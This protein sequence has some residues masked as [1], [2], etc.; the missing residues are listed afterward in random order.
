[1]PRYTIGLFLLASLSAT[2]M[3][4]SQKMLV[5]YSSYWIYVVANGVAFVLSLVAYLL[6]DGKSSSIQRSPW[7]LVLGVALVLLNLGYVRLYQQ[8][9]NLAYVPLMVT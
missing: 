8:N 1:M 4:T 9:I 7:M 2:L 5:G 6:M 3:V